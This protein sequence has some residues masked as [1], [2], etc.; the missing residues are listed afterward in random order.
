MHYDPMIAKVIAHA[1]TRDAAIDR[2]R[3][4]LAEFHILGLPTN[5]AFLTA[6]LDSPAFRAGD[7]HTAYLDE[8]G[9]GAGRAAA[10]AGRRARGRRGPRAT[11]TDGAPA[12]GR[13]DASRDPWA[14]LPG[15]RG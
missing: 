7:V 15:W 14:S 1:E 5:I 12:A 8:R 3:A 10:I 13:P 9:S 2:M 11:P 6:V 4:A